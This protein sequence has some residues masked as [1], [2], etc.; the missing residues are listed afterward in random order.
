MHGVRVMAH[1]LLFCSCIEREMDG[2]VQDMGPVCLERSI[3]I[4][5]I[6]LMMMAIFTPGHLVCVQSKRR[7]TNACVRA[8]L[9]ARF[10]FICLC[11]GW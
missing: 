3:L 1:G 6:L 11:V 10:V 8:E 2:T 7:K 9:T 5:L 4:I